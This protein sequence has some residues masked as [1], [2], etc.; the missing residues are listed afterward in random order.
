MSS[1]YVEALNRFAEWYERVMK[2]DVPEPTAVILA[3][4]DGEGR[5]S[6]RTVLLKSFDERGFVFFSNSQS[7]KGR[8]LEEN[9]RAA[10]CFY[11]PELR[12]QVHIEGSVEQISENQIDSY[13]RTRDRFSQIGA[14]A[15]EQSAPLERREILEARFREREGKFSG[16]DIPRPEH[17]VGYRVV[18]DMIE[19]WSGREHRLHERVRYRLEGEEWEKTLLN[20]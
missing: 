18:P 5:P 20:P 15:S 6:A 3:T 7:I 13:W 17:W 19:F 2:L 8:Q 10:L 14:W 16:G 4:S 12:R 1:V 9:P 11:W